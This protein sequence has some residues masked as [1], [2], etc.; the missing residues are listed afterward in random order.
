VSTKPEANE[1]IL[2]NSHDGASSYQLLAG[3]FRLCPAVHRAESLL[4]GGR[5]AQ[6]LADGAAWPRVR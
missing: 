1:I 4:P 5:G 2:I 6:V 3:L